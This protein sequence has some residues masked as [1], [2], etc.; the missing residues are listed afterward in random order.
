MQG[1]DLALTPGP[2]PESTLASSSGVQSGRGRLN[3]SALCSCR[4]LRRSP[5]LTAFSAYHLSPALPISIA[6]KWGGRELPVVF[7]TRCSPHSPLPTTANGCLGRSISAL[8]PCR[9]LLCAPLLFGWDASSS[10]VPPLSAPADGYCVPHCFSA[11]C[12]KQRSTSAL[13]TC[14]W[15]LC[16]PLLF[17]WMPQAAEYLRPLP[18]QRATEIATPDG[19]R[20]AITIFYKDEKWRI[21]KWAL[22]ERRGSYAH[23]S[24]ADQETS[25]AE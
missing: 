17:G 6:S 20:F 13:C 12:L 25:A 15:L 18:L 4:G 19:V 14:R 21:W 3:N 5:R 11:G 10:G 24:C 7:T 22:L 1:C 9:G 2:L 16:A 23:C 8:C